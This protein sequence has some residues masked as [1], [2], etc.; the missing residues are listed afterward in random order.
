MAYKRAKLN[1]FILD[2]VTEMFRIAGHPYTWDC[3]MEKVGPDW[4]VTL[5]ITPEQVV[6]WKTWFMENYPYKETKKEKQRVWEIVWFQYG[7][8]EERE[9]SLPPKS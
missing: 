9:M 7:L 4:F 3:V 5:T 2:S 8:I 1:N 6:Q